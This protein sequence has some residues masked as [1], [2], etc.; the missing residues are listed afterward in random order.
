[1]F[2]TSF[3]FAN[4]YWAPRRPFF[5]AGSSLPSIAQRHK[6]VVSYFGHDR[7]EVHPERCIAKESDIMTGLVVVLELEESV[8]ALACR[9]D[10]VT[11]SD[12]EEPL[13]T[14]FP[15]SEIKKPP[16]PSAQGICRAQMGRSRV[17]VRDS[18][19][20]GTHEELGS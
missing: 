2:T 14:V 10:D 6:S 4:S 12:E 8:L 7:F 19:T 16:V 17:V 1:M 11:S 5:A 9:K 15:S 3:A 13:S 20:A 18:Q